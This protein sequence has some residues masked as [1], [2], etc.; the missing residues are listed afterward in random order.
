VDEGVDN[1]RTF[2]GLLELRLGRKVRHV[3]VVCVYGIG[4]KLQV[5]NR[6]AE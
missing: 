2:V 1:G 3:C 5:W 4:Y 6:K